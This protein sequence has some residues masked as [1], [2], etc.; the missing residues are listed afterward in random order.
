M[1]KSMADLPLFL[2][3]SCVCFALSVV[4]GWLMAIKHFKDHPLPPAFAALHGIASLGGL[5]ALGWAVF[6]VGAKG[7]PIVALLFFVIAFLD[8]F[9]LLS[10]HIM[11]KKHPSLAIINHG[12]VAA[13]GIVVLILAMLM[14]S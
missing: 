13:Q 11:K 2:L 9:L 14:A 4:S 10:M 1:T 12:A 7:Y 5:A 3:I 8:G 6:A